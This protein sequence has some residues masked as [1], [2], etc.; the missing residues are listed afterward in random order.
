MEGGALGNQEYDAGRAGAFARFYLLDTE[1]TLATAA[2]RAV[3][4]KTIRAVISRSAFVALFDFGGVYRGALPAPLPAVLG[5]DHVTPG[6]TE[7][8]RSAAESDVF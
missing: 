6:A 2:S 7:R 5:L 1:M 8:I 3:T 4:W